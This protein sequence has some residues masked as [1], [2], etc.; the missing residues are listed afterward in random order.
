MKTL[1]NLLYVAAF[2]A[3]ILIGGQRN[4]EIDRWIYQQEMAREIM[5]AEEAEVME[6]TMPIEIERVSL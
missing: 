1:M 5:M 3:M 4:A 2:I 6:M